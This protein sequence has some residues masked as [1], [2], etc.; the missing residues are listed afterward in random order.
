MPSGD[1]SAAALF[2]FMFFV[3]L[4]LKFVYFILPL[5]MCGRVYYHC[6]WFGD[7]I[8]GVAVG[9]RDVYQSAAGCG[10]PYALFGAISDG[11][12]F[13]GFPCAVDSCVGRCSL[14]V[15]STEAIL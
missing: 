2:C 15:S 6:H 7:T 10:R 14:W 11:F 5:V 8:V 13:S 3:V 4:D 1:A 9:T 12:G